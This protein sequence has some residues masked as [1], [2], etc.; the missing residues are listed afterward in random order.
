MVEHLPGMHK[1]LGSVLLGL[2][3]L[4]VNEFCDSKQADIV[5][6]LKTVMARATPSLAG[7][8]CSCTSSLGSQRHLWNVQRS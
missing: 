5:C 3:H 2:S 8:W 4:E 1:A 6:T 7:V